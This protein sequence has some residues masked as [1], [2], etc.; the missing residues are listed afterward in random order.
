MDNHECSD[1][2]LEEN[3]S[4]IKQEEVNTILNNKNILMLELW[5]E[6]KIGM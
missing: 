5:K 2:F 3:G 6:V 1:T 4:M